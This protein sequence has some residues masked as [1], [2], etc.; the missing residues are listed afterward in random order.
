MKQSYDVYRQCLYGLI[1]SDS[2]LEPTVATD[3]SLGK[4]KKKNAHRSAV[5][6]MDDNQNPCSVDLKQAYWSMGIDS[7]SS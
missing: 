4:K 5:N 2:V 6:Q 7:I 3:K 1:E